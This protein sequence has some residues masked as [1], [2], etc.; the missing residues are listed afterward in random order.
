MNIAHLIQLKQIVVVLLFAWFFFLIRDK[1]RGKWFEDSQDRDGTL[2]MFCVVGLNVFMWVY[3]GDKLSGEVVAGI[4]IG[5][6]QAITLIVAYFYKSKNG[7][8]PNEK[9]TENP[10]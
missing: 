5:F 10:D 9:A 3:F 7:E 4:A 8:K 1:L 6:A 2:I